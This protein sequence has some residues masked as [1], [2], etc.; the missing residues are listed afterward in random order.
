[1]E[2][3]HGRPN[4]KSVSDELSFDFDSPPWMAKFW[5]THRRKAVVFVCVAALWLTY[6]VAFRSVETTP[7]VTSGVVEWKGLDGGI[8]YREVFP[9]ATRHTILFLHGHGFT[10]E[11]WQRLGTLQYFGSRGCRAVAVD[12]PGYGHSRD[13]EAPRSL[14]ERGRFL[15]TLIKKLQLDR[16]VLVSPSVSG[17]FSLPFVLSPG[18]AKL[19]RAFVAVAPVATDKFDA[20]LFDSLQLPTLIVYGEQDVTVGISS[21]EKLKRI[22]GS[23]IHVMRGAGH[24]CYVANKD[25]FLSALDAFME[26]LKLK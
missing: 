14:A 23:V 5:R 18:N 9:I 11:T 19:L 26:N 10:A 17:L 8:A 7:S 15:W 24:A 25:E 6:I 13:V 20:G 2:N 21:R 1:M 3:K 4:R 12:L 22:P 16:P